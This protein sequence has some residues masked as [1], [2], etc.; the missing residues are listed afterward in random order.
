MSNISVRLP[1]ALLEALEQEARR[2]KAQRS[3]LIR[4]AVTEYLKRSEQDRFLADMVKEARA[5]YQDPA[6]RREALDTIADFDAI[7]ADDDEPDWWK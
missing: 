2:Q 4:T 5:A 1:E 6:I 3:E 7:E